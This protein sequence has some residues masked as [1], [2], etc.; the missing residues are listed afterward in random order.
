MIVLETQIISIG[1][2]RHV[3]LLRAKLGWSFRLL[4]KDG[5]KIN[6]EEKADGKFTFL[7]Y[8]FAVCPEHS[9]LK[10]DPQTVI[11]EQF[12]ET[13]SDIILYHWESFLL[14]SIIRD[15]YYYYVDED[16]KIIYQ[17][18]LQHINKNASGPRK[19]VF[20]LKRKNRIL[21]K[22]QEYLQ[23]N[24]SIVIDG[25][26]RFRL[27]EYINELRDATDKAVDDFLMNKEYK[28]FIQLLK[29]FVEIQEP[30]FDTIHVL[31][32]NSGA[33]QLYDDKMQPVKNDYLGGFLS[34]IMDSD[35][36]HEDMLISTLVTIA[37]PKIAFHYKKG[38]RYTAAIDTLKK[39]FA[40][41]VSECSGCELCNPSK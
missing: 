11:K 25:F 23:S 1:S 3:D 21:K 26:I 37:P 7:F 35:I 10:Y 4:E 18:A 28:E 15:N 38:E 2:T 36:D 12:A 20:R 39:I 13:I 5:V 8:S 30:C 14:K 6:M 24:N 32:D 40:G 17:H 27:K 33:F 16:K 29:Y 34:D 31:I 9:R 19:S 22:L 41:K